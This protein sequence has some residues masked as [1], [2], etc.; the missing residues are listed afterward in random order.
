MVV[1]PLPKADNGHTV[2]PLTPYAVRDEAA[3][4]LHCPRYKDPDR[5]YYLTP[6]EALSLARDLTAY[7]VNVLQSGGK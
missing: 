5:V 2:T 1:V 7:A 3:V 6:I 4:R